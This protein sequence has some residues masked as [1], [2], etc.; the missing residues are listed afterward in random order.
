M[1]TPEQ[2]LV[3][4]I[5]AVRPDWHPQGVAA[6]LGKIDRPFAELARAAIVFATTRP[7]QTTPANIAKDGPHWH[8][9][10]QPTAKPTPTP[11]RSPM[12]VCAV[13][14]TP[15]GSHEGQGHTY[16][17]PGFTAAAPET[18]ER[19]RPTFTRGAPDA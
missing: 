12:P 8:V 14:G 17:E 10:G 4:V 3:N 5:V 16:E 18:I 11:A 6:V 15:W 19:V 13:C 9:S 7:D 2:S 1:T